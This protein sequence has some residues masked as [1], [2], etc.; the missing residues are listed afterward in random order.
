MN[1][2]NLTTISYV[3]DVY[4]KQKSYKNIKKKKITTPLMFISF[5]SLY[6]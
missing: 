6:V 2:N 4:I 5:F 3:N 1:N